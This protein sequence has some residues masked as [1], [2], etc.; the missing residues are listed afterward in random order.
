MEPCPFS[1]FQARSQSN[2]LRLT[3]PEGEMAF[4]EVI[5]VKSFPISVFNEEKKIPYLYG[6]KNRLV[7]T[8]LASNQNIRSCSTFTFT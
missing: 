3:L 7:C 4:R 1:C 6:Y 5:R 8:I 2:G